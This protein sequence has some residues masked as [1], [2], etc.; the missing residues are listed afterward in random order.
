[1]KKITALFLAMLMMLNMA[2]TTLAATVTPE[3]SATEVKA[4]EDVTVTITLD[5]AMRDILSFEYYLYFEFHSS[6]F[7]FAYLM[8]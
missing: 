4:G 2:I 1:M 8:L 7:L 6:L 3:L 5:E